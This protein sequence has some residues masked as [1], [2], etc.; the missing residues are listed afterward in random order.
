MT[1][2]TQN[3]N[4]SI[5]RAEK[6]L[7]QCSSSLWEI[8][9][10]FLARLLKQ[11]IVVFGQRLDLQLI[12]KAPFHPEHFLFL[13]FF[14]IC[15]FS[16]F[17]EEIKSTAPIWATPYNQGPRK[18][19]GYHII[20]N[21]IPPMFTVHNAQKMAKDYHNSE[22]NFNPLETVLLFSGCMYCIYT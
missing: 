22:S 20:H 17:R 3:K 16:I 2:Q 11:V 9:S 7:A 21:H 5:H 12:E 15:F 8:M 19:M 10:V 18:G 13:F 6:L 14:V 4:A 1:D